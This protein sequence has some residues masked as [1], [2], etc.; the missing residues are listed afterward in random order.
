MT[1]KTIFDKEFQFVDDDF[2]YN[3]QPELTKRL[4]NITKQIDQN[5]I[6]EII[7]WKVSRYALVDSETLILLNSVK[8]KSTNLDEEKT[9]MILRKLIKIK[10]IKL[11]VASTILRFINKYTF[12]IIDQRVYRIINPDKNLEK[13]SC[14]KHQDIEGQIDLYLNYLKDLKKYCGE[15]KIK[16]E[17]ADRVFYMADKRI[18]K[19][20]KLENH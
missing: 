8:R 9:R 19:A 6:N 17:D 15:Y 14:I 10:G 18:N 4:D 7:L 16:F 5:I 2:I 13:E 3:Y 20:I 12:Q 1:H 11:A